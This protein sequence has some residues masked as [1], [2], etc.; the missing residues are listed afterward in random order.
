MITRHQTGLTADNMVREEVIKIGLDFYKPVP[1]EGY[2]FVLTSA[3]KPDKKLTI[4]I[5]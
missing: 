2:D 4:Q 3:N 5:K 1:E